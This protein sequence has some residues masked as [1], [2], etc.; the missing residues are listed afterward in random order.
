[1]PVVK[2]PYRAFGK[3][4]LKNVYT[5]GEQITEDMPENRQW[6]NFITKGSLRNF[7]DSANTVIGD[8]NTG[9]MWFPDDFNYFSGNVSYEVDGETELWCIAGDSNDDV[10]PTCNKWILAAG[11]STTINNGTKLFFC[12]GDITVNGKQVNEPTRLIITSGDV[13]VTAAEDSYAIIF[14]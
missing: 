8:S 11:Q 12:R 6:I 2:T 9:D 13:T 7:S 5:D 4:I 3:S 14:S 1:M 10:L